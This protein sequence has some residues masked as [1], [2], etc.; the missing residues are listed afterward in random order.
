MR[1]LRIV[2][3]VVVLL[4][5]ASG[6]LLWRGVEDAAAAPGPH[7]ATVRVHV[8]PG[9]GLRSVLATLAQRGAL[10]DAR[11]VEIWLRLHG[12]NPKVRAGTYDIPP[13]ASALEVLARL[14]RGEVVL[15]SLTIVEGATFGDFRRALEA[16]PRVRHTLRGKSDDEVMSA[17][18]RTGL[19]PEGRFFPDTYRFADGTTDAE[20]LQLAYRQM[21]GELEAAWA[22][23]QADLP[24]KTA[25]E[26]LI[27]ASIVEKETALPTERP[28]VAGVYTTRLRKGMRLQSDPTVIYGIGATYDGDIR[29]RD[30]QADTP[31][32]TYDRAGLPTTPI[33]MQERVAQRT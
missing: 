6:L 26:A 14:E 23:R 22:A 30:L 20:I 27:L 19:H 16:H 21:S 18:G 2:V 11:R 8:R 5:V 24:V 10:A 17:L 25:Y 4:A 32:N 1:T 7:Q 13:R 15:E 12:R 29:S 31:Y 3:V 33:A 9:E 28:M